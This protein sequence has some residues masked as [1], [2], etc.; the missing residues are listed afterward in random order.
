GREGE[1]GIEGGTGTRGGGKQAQKRSRFV[2]TSI[3]DGATVLS[4]VGSYR[5]EDAAAVD[6]AKEREKEKE[7]EEVGE[8]RQPR[9]TV[10]PTEDMSKDEVV[11]QDLSTGAVKRIK[12]QQ[13]QQDRVDKVT[14]TQLEG[15][16]I[17]G[18][19]MVCD[20]DGDSLAARTDRGKQQEDVPKDGG[21]GQPTANGDGGSLNYIGEGPMAG[22]EGRSDTDGIGLNL[23]ATGGILD[24]LGAVGGGEKAVKGTGHQAKGFRGEGKS[25]GLGW[26]APPMAMISDQERNGSGGF[27]GG[28]G[29]G[30][31]KG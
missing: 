28:G 23:E 13:L 10:R 6:A 4:S 20:D 11:L 12:R 14:H 5:L 31:G 30:E 19:A 2:F 22:G 7:G 9:E 15:K 21:E 24:A 25:S 16:G 26:K 1:P 18:E 3:E 17:S 8:K 27:S 29:G